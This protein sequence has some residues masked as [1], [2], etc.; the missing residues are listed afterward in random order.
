MG[1]S[2]EQRRDLIRSLDP[3]QTAIVVGRIEADRL[4]HKYEDHEAKTA[5]HFVQ[6]GGDGSSYGIP[7]YTCACLFGAD[8]KFRDLWQ[9]IRRRPDSETATLVAESGRPLA[10]GPRVDTGMAG[11]LTRYRRSPRGRHRAGKTGAVG[12]GEIEARDVH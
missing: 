1:W 7:E 9:E 12:T 4:A 11:Q 8:P 3:R 10:V 5:I 2:G 6:S